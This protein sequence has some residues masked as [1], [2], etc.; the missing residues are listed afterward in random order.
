LAP[1]ALSTF[2]RAAS[3]Q[4]A[5]LYVP[6]Y[7]SIFDQTRRGELRLTS[8]LSVHNL[9]LE[10]TVWITAVI[11]VDTSGRPLREL[12]STPIE[13]G[14]LATRHFVVPAHDGSGGAGANFLVK[15]EADLVGSAPRVE[16]L[17]ISTV[18]QQGISFLTE[19]S[20]VKTLTRT[21]TAAP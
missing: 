9:R 14:P 16:A 20:L 1:A 3:S 12:V 6:V 11:Y 2:G 17:M 15:W 13:L 8:T 5:L 7:S 4:G 19:G 18:G 10:D 21:A